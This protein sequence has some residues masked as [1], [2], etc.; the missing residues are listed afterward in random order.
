ML[1]NLGHVC[2]FVRTVRILRWK[3]CNSQKQHYQYDK[4]KIQ[5]VRHIELIAN[6][7]RLAELA[8]VACSITLMEVAHLIKMGDRLTVLDVSGN[9][10]VDDTCL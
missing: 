3:K 8:L 1:R 9:V 5:Y 2:L 6:L 10:G 4:L 7:P